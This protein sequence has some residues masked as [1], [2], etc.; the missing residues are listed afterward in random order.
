LSFPGERV[1]L[2]FS[3]LADVGETLLG[4]SNLAEGD[5]TLG[6]LALGEI[7]LG[8]YC[9]G[10]DGDLFLGKIFFV[11]QVGILFDDECSLGLESCSSEWVSF[12]RLSRDDA[13]LIDT[14]LF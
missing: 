7:D 10:L 13:L 14:F 4:E 2:T 12:G 1:E 9:D 3:V 8:E 6:I 5:I 11:G